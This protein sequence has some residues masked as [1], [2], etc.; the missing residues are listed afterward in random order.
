M[1]RPQAF[2]DDT[3]F[4]PAEALYSTTTEE[5]DQDQDTSS[6]NRLL[7]GQQ[8][9][10]Q[11]LYDSS[12]QSIAGLALEWTQRGFPLNVRLGD[13]KDGSC[14][15]IQCKI[16]SVAMTRGPRN[17]FDRSAFASAS[18]RQDASIPVDRFVSGAKIAAQ[19]VNIQRQLSVD[20]TQGSVYRVKLVQQEPLF[21]QVKQR[22]WKDQGTVDAIM[23]STAIVR[24][25]E[26]YDRYVPFAAKNPT[27][28]PDWLSKSAAFNNIDNSAYVDAIGCAVGDAL[29]RLKVSPFFCRLYGTMRYGVE[30]EFTLTHTVLETKEKF[31]ENVYVPIPVQLL[32]MQPLDGTVRQ[33]VEQGFFLANPTRPEAGVN[34]AKIMSLYAQVIFGLYA[35]Q[36]YYGLVHN[37]AHTENVMYEEVDPDTVLYYRLGGEVYAVPTFGRVYHLIDFGM[38]DIAALGVRSYHMK[39]NYALYDLAGKQ[40]DLYRF[41]VHFIEV[42]KQYLDKDWYR[43]GSAPQ[44][45]A[46]IISCDEQNRNVFDYYDAGK[47]E[48]DDVDWFYYSSIYSHCLAS[49]PWKNL[50]WF[51]AYAVRPDTVPRKAL[52][53][54]LPPLPR[55]A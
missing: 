13:S 40:N 8:W 10:A 55:G 36:S 27:Q 37:D 30:Q 49:V 39:N 16:D 23:K 15:T 14:T 2:V 21:E 24:G 9:S 34:A 25:K 47:I 18:I 52:V 7:R 35:A 17:L 41:T 42:M 43:T 6:S 51:G 22:F 45:L 32:F 20:S 48:A 5:E 54:T 31:E 33:L 50:G 1:N 44:L 26:L 46:S 12:E 4:D 38:C 11:T 28:I 19:V 53:Y 3:N 29:V